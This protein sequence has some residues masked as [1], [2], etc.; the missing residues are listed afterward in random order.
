[1]KKKQLAADANPVNGGVVTPTTKGKK[2][3][4]IPVK[5]ADFSS[6]ALSVN[7]KWKLFPTLTLLWITQ[8]AYE[9]LVNSFATNLANRL[10]V[11]SNR[12][13]Q[14][15]SLA[16]INNQ[17]DNAVTDVKIYITKKFKKA[18]ATAQFA[19]YGI[20][21]EGSHYRLPKDNDKRLL[22][23]PMMAAAIAADGFGDEEFG[24]AFWAA[25]MSSFKTALKATADTS[26]AVSSKVSAKDSDREQ[27]NKVLVAIGHLI[28]ANYPDTKDA[29]MREWG[30]IKQNY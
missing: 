18:N 22:A 1:M 4:S 27:I 17:I 25:T 8:A 9:T 24:T 11:G 23:L 13:S 10:A 6:L 2:T 5:D 15:F 29:V 26:K 28:T 12:P 30:F 14:T 20:V 3:K 16:Q 7:A 19:R 21:K